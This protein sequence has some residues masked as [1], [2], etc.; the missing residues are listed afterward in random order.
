MVKNLPDLCHYGY[1]FKH[2]GILVKILYLLLVS[3]IP[4]P[5]S[6]LFSD[7]EH[8]KK[9]SKSVPSFLQKEVKQPLHLLVQ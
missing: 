5:S 3:S 9:M 1:L 4:S 8:L 7:P 2:G 6:S